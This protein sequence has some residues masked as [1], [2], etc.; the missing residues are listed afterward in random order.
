LNSTSSKRWRLKDYI[1]AGDIA[2]TTSDLSA[3]DE[4]GAKSGGGG[5]PSCL[6]ASEPATVAMTEEKL[7]PVVSE[8]AAFA[9]QTCTLDELEAGEPIRRRCDCCSQRKLRRRLLAG[10][11]FFLLFIVLYYIPS[12]SFFT[13]H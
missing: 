2:L 5:I 1:S 9:T 10:L 4:A 11:V 8:K 13:C 6:P 7:V 3:I 12:G